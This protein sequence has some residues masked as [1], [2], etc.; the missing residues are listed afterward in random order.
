M[1]PPVEDGEKDWG[2]RTRTDMVRGKTTIP[3]TYLLRRC[4]KHKGLSNFMLPHLPKHA[5]ERI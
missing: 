4:K 3:L 2:V 5:E 1:G